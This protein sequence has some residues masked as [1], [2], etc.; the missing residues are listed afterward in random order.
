[1]AEGQM[2][3]LERHSYMVG[4]TFVMTDVAPAP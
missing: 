3:N 1:M 2:L 4:A